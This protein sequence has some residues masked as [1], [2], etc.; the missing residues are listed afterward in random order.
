MSIF[1]L[2]DL[3]LAEAT[4]EKRM[5]VFGPSWE[6]Y[7]EK[8]ECAWRQRVTADDLVLLPGDI[9]WAMRLEEAKAD[10]D[11]IDRLPGTK[12]MIRGNHDYWWG[13]IQKIRRAL[14]ST[15][16]ALQNDCFVWN[17]WVIG[18]SR[19]W[20]TEEYTFNTFIEKRE[21]PRAKT[22]APVSP[23][24]EEKIF[25]RELQRLEMSL[26]AMQLHKGRKVVMTHYPPIG[27]DLAPSRASALLEAYQVEKCFFGHLHN[28][29]PSALPFGTARGVEYTLVSADYVDFVPQKV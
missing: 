22:T 5:D 16:R 10:L 27:A 14:P 20:D 26:Q 6:N 21:N 2:A 9:S 18:G 15:I 23:K 3:H 12:V 8:I 11:W 28:V 13:S 17:G 4:P 19:L 25:L 1:A 7:S 24:E 29:R